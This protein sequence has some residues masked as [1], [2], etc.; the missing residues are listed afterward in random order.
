MEVVPHM[1][2]VIVYV[3]GVCWLDIRYHLEDS[4]FPIAIVAILGT[5]IGLLLAFRTNSLQLRPLVGSQNDLGAIVNDSRTLV[6]QLLSSLAT[7]PPICPMMKRCANG[8]PPDCL[9]LRVE[10]QPAGTGPDPGHECIDRRTGTRPISFQPQCSQQHSACAGQGSENKIRGKS[11]RIIPIHRTGKDIDSTYEL[12]GRLRADKEY[13]LSHVLH[14]SDQRVD[15]RIRSL[16]AL[17][18][19]GSTR[20]RTDCDIFDFVVWIPVN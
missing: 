20:D 18:A 7:G 12:D 8:V 6:R 4:H 14:S 11:A 17:W 3:L 16:S 13:R 15:L 1:L 19:L 5:V 10:S 9:V 2:P